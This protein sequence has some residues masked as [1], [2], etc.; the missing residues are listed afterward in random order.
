MG[1]SYPWENYH[2]KKVHLINQI[3]HDSM[4]GLYSCKELNK[5]ENQVKDKFG[6]LI[7]TLQIYLIYQGIIPLDS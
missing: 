3:T 4:R 2:A 1:N 6:V 5:S 7:Q